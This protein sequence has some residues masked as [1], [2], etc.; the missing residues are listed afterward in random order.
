MARD[1]LLVLVQQRQRGEG[2]A[3][4]VAENLINRSGMKM[5]KLGSNRTILVSVLV[6]DR[7]LEYLFLAG[8]VLH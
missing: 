6:R 3:V 8:F 2:L 5:Q 4:A 7:I 1:G